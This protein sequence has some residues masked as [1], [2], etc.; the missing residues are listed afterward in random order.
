MGSHKTT[1]LGMIV[2]DDLQRHLIPI[3]AQVGSVVQ[4][5]QQLEFAIGLGLTLLKQMKSTEFTDEEFEGSMN[6]FSEKTL[7]RL[8]GEFRKYVV[9]DDFA[10]SSLK[11]ALKERNYVVHHL[12]QENIEKLTSIDGRKWFKRRVKEANKNM[13]PGFEIVD[14]LVVSLASIC[15]LNINDITEQ[16]KTSIEV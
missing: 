8:I 9:M 4:K 15:G 7:G 12:F 16:M 3:Y 2:E 14:S 6:L 11:L 13:L 5:S 1:S 10:I